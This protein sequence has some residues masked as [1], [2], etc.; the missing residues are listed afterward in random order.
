MES[1]NTYMGSSEF[2]LHTIESPVTACLTNGVAAA[3]GTCLKELTLLVESDSLLEKSELI[4]QKYC[5][6]CE[7]QS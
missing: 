3:G 4:V 7:L 1:Q 6:S 2:Q 5:T